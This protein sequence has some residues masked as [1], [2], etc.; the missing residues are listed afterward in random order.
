VSLAFAWRV[1]LLIEAVFLAR[2]GCALSPALRLYFA[3]DLARSA[4]LALFPG[5]YAALWCHTEPVAQ[6]ILWLVAWDLAA[7]RRAWRELLLPGAGMTLAAAIL[8]Q[9]RPA[10][11]WVH[12]TLVVAII[13]VS[14]VLLVVEHFC[15]PMALLAAY[16]CAEAVAYIAVMIG[17][18]NDPRPAAVMV[19][20]QSACFL[21][22]ILGVARRREPV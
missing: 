21:A 10:M 5:A 15:L 2:L 3:A 4:L 9:S 11:L 17:A 7:G 19:Y 8:A 22:W 13:G 6:A 18:E 20:G 14:V 16:F 1:S 12:G